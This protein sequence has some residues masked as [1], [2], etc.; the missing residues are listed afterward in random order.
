MSFRWL[1][2]IL[3]AAV[4]P[5]LFILHHT[6]LWMERRG[7]IFYQQTRPD[8]RNVGPA[9]L[10]IQRLFE[11]GKEHVIEQVKKQSVQEDDDGGPDKAGK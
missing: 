4:I 11:P 10:E 1:P 8:P 2:V 5:A 7:W 6:L 9:F 3:V